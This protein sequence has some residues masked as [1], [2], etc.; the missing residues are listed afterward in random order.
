MSISLKPELQQFIEE[1]V[2]SGRFASVEAV[3]EEAVSRM[4]DEEVAQLDEDT[5]DAIDESEDQIDRGEYRSW[6]EVSAELRAKY[7]GE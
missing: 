1:Q 4:K 2:K 6:E 5:L 7:L 3:V